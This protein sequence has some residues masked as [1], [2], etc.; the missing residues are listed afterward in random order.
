VSVVAQVVANVAAPVPVEN[1]VEAEEHV[2][3]TDPITKPN[4]AT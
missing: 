1:A 2:E 4:V 3:R